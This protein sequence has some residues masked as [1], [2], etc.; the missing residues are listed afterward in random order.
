MELTKAAGISFLA[1]LACFVFGTPDAAA[2]GHAKGDIGL[3]VRQC[4]AALVCNG[5]YLVAQS[6]KVIYQGAVGRASFEGHK[7]L[8]TDFAFDIGSVS[9]Q[10]TAAAIVRLAEQH[11]LDLD[12]TVATHLPGFPYPAVTIRQLL[13]QTSGIPDVMPHYTEVILSGTAKGPVD[14][15]DVVDVLAASRQ[16]LV[17]I[18]GTTFAYSNTGYTLL[19]KLIANASGKSYADFLR[20]E[21]FVPL[22]M[23]HTWVRTPSMEV[24]TGTDRA[25]GMRVTRNGARKAFDQVPG[26]YLYGAGGIYAT[27]GDLLIW[28]NAL[29]HGKVMSTDHWRE[30]TAPVTLADGSSSPY[31]FGLSLKPSVL[32]QSSVSHGGHWRGFKADLTVLPDQ[33]TTIVI[34]TNNAEDDEVEDARNAFEG[35]L[36]KDS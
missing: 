17:A 13:N 4:G 9:K 16:P 23:T 32:G 18:P 29:S 3:Y 35:I 12:D 21:F 11:K 27:T 22:G 8:T 14:L 20:D 2:S 28:A 5:S 25:Y 31:G 34:L 24:P 33:D 6:G 7:R 15:S 30:A 10:F 36:H 19:G 26:L 1:V